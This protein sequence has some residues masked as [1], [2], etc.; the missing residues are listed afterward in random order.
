MEQQKTEAEKLDQEMR[1][2]IEEARVIIPGVQALF[3]FQTIV[4]FN[5]RFATLETFAKACHTLGLGMVMVSIAMLMT[6]PVYYRACAGQPTR[7]MAK[8]ASLMIR[9]CLV[10]LALGL[11]LDMFTVLF[12]VSKSLWLSINAAA[13]TLILFAVLWYVVPVSDRKRYQPDNRGL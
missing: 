6:P 5:D 13:V 12:V 8:V 3:G 2:I 9:G 1:N 7:H 11:S 4:V 10:P